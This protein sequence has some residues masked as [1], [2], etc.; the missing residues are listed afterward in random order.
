[1]NIVKNIIFLVVLTI[2][3]VYGFKIFMQVN[4]GKAIGTKVAKGFWE[5]TAEASQAIKSKIQS[6][7]AKDEFAVNHRTLPD[8]EPDSPQHKAEKTDVSRS[9][10]GK[11]VKQRKPVAKKPAPINAPAS[12]TDQAGPI[13]PEDQKITAEVLDDAATE[14]KKP[15]M[16]AYKPMTP[17]Q[18]E[19]VS[20]IY[21][22]A[23]EVLK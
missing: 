8:K 20:R 15:E 17:K 6:E 11:V 5:K 13:D 10:K 3:T 16:L 7:M 23:N 22:E 9:K 18:I 4:D 21:R 19:M 14:P 1:M 2:M 12:G